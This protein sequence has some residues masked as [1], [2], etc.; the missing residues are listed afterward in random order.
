[1][2]ETQIRERLRDAVGEARVPPDLR[3]RVETRLKRS[4]RLNGG[5]LMFGFGRTGQLVAAV[6]AVLIVAALVIGV[7]AWRDSFVNSR[8]ANPHVQ[9]QTIKQYQT[10]LG[11]D[12]QDVLNAQSNKC[13]TL[14]DGCPAAAA[15]VIAPLQKWLDDLDGTRPPTRFAYIDAGLRRHVAA[16]IQYLNAA[17]TAY[18]AQDQN[19]MDTAISAAANERDA[20]EIEVGD[21][22]ASSQAS[23]SVYTSVIQSGRSS[24]LT[25]SACQTLTKSGQVS[26]PLTD[27]TCANEIAAMM[28]NVEA[29]QGDLVHDF[30]PDSLATKDARLQADLWAADQALVAMQSAWSGNDEGALQTAHDAF[31]RA[32]ARVEADVTSIL[33]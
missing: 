31:V 4:E 9:G 27:L 19:G 3:S 18:N 28:D 32:Y 12:E 22:V 23:V 1:M 13:S 26:C 15:R 5:P 21:V 14:G 7:R 29:F 11:I 17:V 33:S 8:P 10:M 24:L 30:A 6:V 16:C 2:N 25:C 20:F